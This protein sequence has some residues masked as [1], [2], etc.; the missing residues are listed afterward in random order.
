M[1]LPP[2][3]RRKCNSIWCGVIDPQY[4]LFVFF[5]FDVNQY[6]VFWYFKAKRG[7]RLLTMGCCASADAVQ[8]KT[9]TLVL[10]HSLWGNSFKLALAA[11]EGAAQ[12]GPVNLFSIPETLS[13]EELNKLGVAQAKRT[14]A[15][16][17]LGE[18][19]E[20]G[21]YDSIMIVT[22]GASSVPV[23]VE[24]FLGKAKPLLQ[25]KALSGK[26]ASA[27]TGQHA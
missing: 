4:L 15:H 13:E 6:V 8:N 27:L 21:D 2:S 16:I 10:F 17:A 20:L 3:T 14:F 22:S 18:P 11:A 5:C 1:L 23:Q 12:L 25:K 24:A 19:L 7:T 26:A 9:K